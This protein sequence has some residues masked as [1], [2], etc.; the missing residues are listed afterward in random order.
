[1]TQPPA[2]L[3]GGEVTTLSVARSL[4][5]AGV[6]VHATADANTPSPVRH[7]RAC[8]SFVNVAGGEQAQ[9]RWLEWLERG[10]RDAVLLACSD[11]GLEVV[12]RNRKQLLEWGYRPFE[13]DDRVV[14]AMLDKAETYALAD[15]AGVPAPRTLRLDGPTDLEHALVD[16]PLP[17][18]LKPIASHRFARH[19][20][21]KAVAV[22]SPDDARSVYV[23]LAQAGVPLLATEIV[24]AAAD[25]CVSYYSY[26]D[27]RGEP[28]LHFTKRKV[29]QWPT[30]FGAGCYHATRWDRDVADAGQRFFAAAGVRGLACVEFRRDP[31][32]RLVLIECNHRFTAANEVVLRAGIDL[33]LLSYNRLVGRPIPPVDSFRDGITLWHPVEDVRAFLEY[34]RRGELTA[35]TWARSLARRQHFPVFSWRDPKPSVAR[36][37]ALA[38]RAGRRARAALSAPRGAPSRSAPTPPSRAAPRERS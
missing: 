18:A 3:L 4:S 36:W 25:E 35:A 9:A 27:E 8:S 15:R 23:R 28:L 29:R 2:V 17:F 22:G 12:A 24:R 32:G 26:L 34:R 13:A 7:S 14:L 38:G 10:P 1:V 30:G 33:A 5:A 21:V 19:F 37:A 11:D 6:E 16:L 31:D 20:G